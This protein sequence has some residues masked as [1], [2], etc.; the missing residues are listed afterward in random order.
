M[1]Y[2]CKYCPLKILYCF[3]IVL[4]LSQCKHE[5]ALGSLQSII[6]SPA[7]EVTTIPN[8]K[9]IG[10]KISNAALNIIDPKIVYVAKYQKISFPG[11]DVPSHTGVC[12]DVVIRAFRQ[13]G[14][15]LQQEIHDDM[16]N[17]FAKYPKRWGLTKTDTN[18]DHRRVPN[19]EVFFERKG[20]KQ[21]NS[22]VIEDY[23]PGDIVTWL[24][25]GKMPHIGIVTH[26]KSA[27]GTP[28]V[29]H[30][31]GWGQVLEDWL[32]LHPMVGHYRYR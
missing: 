26:L 3:F 24:I 13:L 20:F 14:I 1:F 2:W 21:K 17:N 19:V 8:P 22:A 27:S 11:G 31:A 25:D 28:L 23:K 7:V 16:K 10:E 4:L 6:Y 5:K 12:T 29:V 18:I 15:D 32:F 30:N 9:I